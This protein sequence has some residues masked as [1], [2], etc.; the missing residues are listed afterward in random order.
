M[1]I[2]SWTTIDVRVLKKIITDNDKD[3]N[4]DNKKESGGQHFKKSV[5]RIAEIPNS[6]IN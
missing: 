1:A 4:N 5:F 6:K 2:K 3:N